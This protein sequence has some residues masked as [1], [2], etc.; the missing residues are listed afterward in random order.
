[1]FTPRNR[2]AKLAS[3]LDSNNRQ[4]HWAA[5]LASTNH[6][7]GQ[8][9]CP[10]PLAITTGQQ[11]TNTSVMTMLMMLMMMIMATMTIMIMMLIMIMMMM[12]LMLM[13][14]MVIGMM[15][16]KYIRTCACMSVHA[17]QYTCQVGQRELDN[18][19]GQPHWPAPLASTINT[20]GQQHWPA[21][22]ASSTGVKYWVVCN[23]IMFISIVIIIDAVGTCCQGCCPMVQMLRSVQM[24]VCRCSNQ[25]RC[26]DPCSDQCSDQFTNV[27]ISADDQIN[28]CGCVCGCGCV[29]CVCVWVCVCLCLWMCVVCCVCV[30]RCSDQ[31]RCPNP[32]S[33]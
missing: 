3:K 7:T 18:T 23:T 14:M 17:A 32:C 9:H 13:G 8:Q 28:V 10:S 6:T 25:C 2:L 12:M 22:L 29:L 33:A 26:P 30:C 11:V 1:V 31:R 16:S 19:T 20:T 24:C 21:P 5:P 4:H 15:N 27:Q